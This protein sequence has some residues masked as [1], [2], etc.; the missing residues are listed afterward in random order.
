MK[1]A[2]LEMKLNYY[3]YEIKIMNKE[4]GYKDRKKVV[5]GVVDRRD[6]KV[7]CSYTGYVQIFKWLNRTLDKK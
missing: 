1:R 5:Y 6:N 4:L 3:G 7:Q 2:E